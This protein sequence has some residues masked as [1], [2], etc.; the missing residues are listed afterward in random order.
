MLKVVGISFCVL[1]CSILLKEYNR[2][3]AALLSLAGGLFAFLAVFARIRGL[4]T[5]FNRITSSLPVSAEYI[6]IMLKVLCIVIVT[7]LVADSCRDN[8][9]NALASFTELAAKVLVLA[10]SMPLFE[11]LLNIVIGL[12]K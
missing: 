9:E 11:T 3:I 8:G 10:I 2:P 6:S 7:K 12:V 1:I 4:M 5:S